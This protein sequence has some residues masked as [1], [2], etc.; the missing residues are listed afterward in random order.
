MEK[1]TLKQQASQ[2]AIE[3]LQNSLQSGAVLGVGTGS[4][5]NEFIKLLPQIKHD[6]TIVSS[7]H[8]TSTLLKKNNLAVEDLNTVTH[9]DYYVDGADEIDADLNMVKGGGGAMTGEKVLASISKKFLCIAEANKYVPKLG[10]FPIAVEVLPYARSI[11]GRAII[12]LGGTP[13]YREGFTTDNGN[14]IID[15]YHPDF[16]INEVME[17]TINNITGVVENGIFCHLPAN[18]L[19]LSRDTQ[20]ERIYADNHG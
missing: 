13:V 20:V 19:F 6:I 8:Q 2:D 10:A 15:I 17:T 4:T 16:V 14:I 7:S 1:N 9:I 12:Q 11:V 18:I 3:Y 5:V